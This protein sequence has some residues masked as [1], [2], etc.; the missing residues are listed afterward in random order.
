M[1]IFIRF[2]F[3][4]IQFI[5]TGVCTAVAVNNNINSRSLLLFDAAGLSY[6][7]EMTQMEGQRWWPVC[8]AVDVVML[9]DGNTVVM[10]ELLAVGRISVFSVVTQS[11]LT[12][13]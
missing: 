11:T 1:N 6:K 3:I 13:F 9:L 7:C 5:I 10:P 2:I 8:S 12:L 4:F